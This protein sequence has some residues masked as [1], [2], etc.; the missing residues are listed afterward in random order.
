MM[1]WPESQPQQCRDA[2]DAVMRDAY[3]PD[4]QDPLTV[5]F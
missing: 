1:S 3:E 5:T 4:S 2:C